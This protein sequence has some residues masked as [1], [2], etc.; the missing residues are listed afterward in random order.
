MKDK[1]AE[2]ALAALGEITE[3][4][5]QSVEFAFPQADD[6][7]NLYRVMKDTVASIF[8]NAG[9]DGLLETEKK[10]RSIIQKQPSGEEVLKLTG[11]DLA[12]LDTLVRLD[13][14]GSFRSF[15][16]GAIL[17]PMVGFRVGGRDIRELA[18]LHRRNRFRR[19]IEEFLAECGM[20]EIR[21]DFAE[22]K[23]EKYLD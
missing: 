9:F 1:T 7:E 10:I 18:E 15:K 12:R 21:T 13:W 3:T 17:A 20:D 19:K 4:F 23:Y 11:F 14:P 16:N 8:Y 5:P 6:P 22:K 2:S